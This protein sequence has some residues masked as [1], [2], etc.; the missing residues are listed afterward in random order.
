M[1]QFHSQIQTSAL[2][3]RFCVANPLDSGS[4][5]Y[6]HE[7][8][9]MMALLEPGAP[10]SLYERKSYIKYIYIFGY[11]IDGVACRGQLLCLLKTRLK[12]P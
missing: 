1:G 8:F 7:R 9:S 5:K 12:N 2:K 6:Q 4:G 11:Q 10:T 3:Q